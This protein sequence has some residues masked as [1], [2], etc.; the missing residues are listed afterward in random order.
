MAERGRMRIE[1]ADEK[2]DKDM[3]NDTGFSLGSAGLNQ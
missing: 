1:G 2:L 3:G